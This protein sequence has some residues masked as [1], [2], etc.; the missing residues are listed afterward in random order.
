MHRSPRR[1]EIGSTHRS[2]ILGTDS[3]KTAAK[4]LIFSD[5]R[6]YASERI[7]VTGYREVHERSEVTL[8]AIYSLPDEPSPELT[9]T[10]IGA[11]Q[12]PLRDISLNGVGEARCARLQ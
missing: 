10:C 2:R 4:R 5:V 6:I 9:L 12:E 11:A 1:S 8:H 3:E 7:V